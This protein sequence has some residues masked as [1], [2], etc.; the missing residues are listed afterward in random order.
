MMNISQLNLPNWYILVHVL[1]L[2][3]FHVG[4]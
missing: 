2:L 3:T 1:N 4:G